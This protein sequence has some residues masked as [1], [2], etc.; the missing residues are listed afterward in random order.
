V[1]FPT[2]LTF[3]K[4][5]PNKTRKGYNM[6]DRYDPN[7][8]VENNSSLYFV[9]GGLV[10]LAVLLGFAFFMTDNNPDVNTI[11]P[12]AGSYNAPIERPMD[13]NDL[14]N[15]NRVFDNDNVRRD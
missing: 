11:T 7:D 1:N 2:M 5:K 15:N 4:R 3:V 12:A 6:R 14:N 9:V 13:S 8:R 10:V